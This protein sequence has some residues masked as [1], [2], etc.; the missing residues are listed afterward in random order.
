MRRIE[1][2]VIGC[3]RKALAYVK[4]Q[5]L[6]FRSFRAV[7]VQVIEYPCCVAHWGRGLS[8]GR[9]DRQRGRVR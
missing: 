8:K 1:C 6:P 2:A 4:F 3:D 7:G 9:F 5:G